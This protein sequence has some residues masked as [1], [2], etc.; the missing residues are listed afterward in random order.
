MEAAN[1]LHN[2]EKWTGHLLSM[3][4]LEG[5]YLKGRLLPEDYILTPRV[6]VFSPLRETM[7]PP[8]SGA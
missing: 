5:G 3:Q 2:F 1:I 8:P 4:E 7:R 6:S